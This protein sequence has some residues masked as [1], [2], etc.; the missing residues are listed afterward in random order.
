MCVSNVFCLCVAG[1]AGDQSCNACPSGT[2]GGIINSPNY[3]NDY[4]ADAGKNGFTCNYFLTASNGRK[5]QLTLAAGANIA[6]KENNQLSVR[7]YKTGNYY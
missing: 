6:L 7:K 2:T 5:V 1:F 3:P 4:T